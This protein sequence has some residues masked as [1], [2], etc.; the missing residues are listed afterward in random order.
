MTLSD[1]LEVWKK[2]GADKIISI[3]L[4]SAYLSQAVVRQS[5]VKLGNEQRRAIG[6]AVAIR[7]VANTA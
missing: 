7:Y 6:L 4:L 2:Q 5:L 1:D 3:D